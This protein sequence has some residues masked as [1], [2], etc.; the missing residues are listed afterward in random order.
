MVN[1]NMKSEILKKIKGNLVVSCQAVEKEPLNNVVAIT[2]VAK[3]CLE[4]GA[5]ILRLSQYDHI[6]SIKG[7]AKDIPIIGLI[8]KTYDG[9]DVFITPTI[10]E[11]NQLIELDVDCIALDATTR[12]R[13][14]ESLETIVKYCKEKVPNKLIMADCSC[15]EDVLHAEKLGFDLIGT[16]LRGYT[17]QTKGLSNL[18]N[19]YHFIREIL[20]CIKTPLIAEGGVWEPYQV[21]DLLDIGCFAVVVGSAITRPKEITQYFLRG[22]K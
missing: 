4:G 10:D 20:S 2:L 11:V 22:I 9:S 17:N 18:D 5:K 12:K 15:L 1:M 6:K 14:K 19:N 13:P 21:K 16:T 8:K 7:I 3:A